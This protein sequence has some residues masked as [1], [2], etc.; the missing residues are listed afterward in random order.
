MSMCYTLSTAETDI[1]VHGLIMN[2]E[3]GYEGET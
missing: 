2:G 1:R 3:K